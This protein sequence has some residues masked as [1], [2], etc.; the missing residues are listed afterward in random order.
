MKK[1]GMG[2]FIAGAAVGGALGVLFAPK[3]GSE[4]R[5]DLKDKACKMANKVK[6]TDYEQI[7]KE[8]EEKICNLK[9][10]VADLDKEKA[11]KIAKEKAKTLK[12]KADDIVALAV[13]KGTPVL[14]DLAQD[15]KEG[16]INVLNATIKKLED[17]KKNSNS[18]KKVP[19][20]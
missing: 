15:A 11:L 5:Q 2:K 10:E 1:K 8:I 14:K 19:K 18:T 3:K 6:D 17:D 4:S 13:E 9:E 12:Q 7:K 20:K 16:V